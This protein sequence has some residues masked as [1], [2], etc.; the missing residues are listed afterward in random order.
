MAAY[1]AQVGFI[2]ADV[3]LQGHDLLVAHSANEIQKDK[4]LE[5]LYLNPLN[6]LIEKNGGSAYP[7]KEKTLTLMI[8]LKT[9]AVATLNVLV[10]KLKKYPLLTSCKT[11]TITIS[12]NTPMPALWKNYPGFIYFDGR[13]YITYTTE[14]QK[15]IRLVSASFQS[16]SKWTGKDE[17]NSVDKK[18]LLGIIES[19]HAMNKPFRFWAI[20]DFENGWRTM[21]DL[22]VD[23]INT[24]D[25]TGAAAFI[26]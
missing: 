14:Q 6:D 3:L 20:P 9:E 22:G 23:I 25:I 17:L 18:K 19:A 2:E 4:T 5:S 8:D 21:I 13:P 12:G 11:L 1:N 26:K 16:Y 7:N 15:R 10:F 24:D